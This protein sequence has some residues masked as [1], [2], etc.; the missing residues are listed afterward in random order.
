MGMFDQKKTYTKVYGG[1]VPYKQYIPV[2]LVVVT[3]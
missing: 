3:E 1:E 2:Y